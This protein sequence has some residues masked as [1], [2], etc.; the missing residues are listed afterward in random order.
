[1]S[2][3]TEADEA[4]CGTC[5]EAKPLMAFAPDRR[6]ANGRRGVCR[7]CRRRK[8]EARVA[9]TQ[10]AFRAS[11]ASVLRCSH[12]GVET[13]LTVFGPNAL[14]PT[15]YKTKCRACEESIARAKAASEAVR[16]VRTCLRCGEAKSGSEFPVRR[17]SALPWCLS[18]LSVYKKERNARRTE[19]IARF[20]AGE[21]PAV[22]EREY[23]AA[24]LRLG[25]PQSKGVLYRYAARL[26]DAP[27]CRARDAGLAFELTPEW[28]IDKLRGV[29]EVTGLPFDLTVKKGPFVPSLDRRV[30]GGPYTLENTQ[31]VVFIYNLAKNKFGHADVMAMANALVERDGGQKRHRK[32]K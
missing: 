5:G 6:R 13:P 2:V 1:M 28:L 9:V 25:G 32:A 21:D 31:V 14:S 27:R 15:G 7:A 23:A 29:C 4:V 26:I 3:T 20:R 17:R 18:C 8:D 24:R 22:I 12:C 30:P 19:M 11:G 16:P 10:A